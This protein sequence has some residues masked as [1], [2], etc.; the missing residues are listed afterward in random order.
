M[1]RREKRKDTR[2]KKKHRKTLGTAQERLDKRKRS[3][4]VS[5]QKRNVGRK[6]RD[7]RD[8]ES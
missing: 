6:Q 3:Q 4:E 5:S 7:Q 8:E 1:D 2:K